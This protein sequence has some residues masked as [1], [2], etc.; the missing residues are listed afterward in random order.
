[1]GGGAALTCIH[2]IDYALW[3]FGPAAA[4]VGMALGK[5]PL[6]T[7]VDEAVAIES[8]TKGQRAV[9]DHDESRA[10]TTHPEPGDHLREGDRHL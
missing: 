4:S 6:G 9:D 2:E 3:I 1:M 5:H 10:E 7:D 8:V